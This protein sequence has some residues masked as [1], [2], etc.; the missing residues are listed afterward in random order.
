MG[1]AFPMVSAVV[2]HSGSEGRADFA[3]SEKML[4]YGKKTSGSPLGNQ[5]EK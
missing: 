1:L 2:P 4:L 3:K 5:E